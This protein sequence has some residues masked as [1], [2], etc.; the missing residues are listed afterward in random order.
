MGILTS[1]GNVLREIRVRWPRSVYECYDCG[2]KHGYWQTP[3]IYRKHDFFFTGETQW[4]VEE[5]V[6]STEREYEY[7]C[8][9]CGAI[10]LY[11]EASHFLL[12]SINFPMTM[13]L[14]EWI[15]DDLESLNNEVDF[16]SI[17]SQHTDTDQGG[18][19]A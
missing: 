3:R 19:S 1:L 4:F 16:P 7:R 17:F 11:D 15:Q 2:A 12:E 8:L 6:D 5:G 10:G 13:K 9:T 18:N 14:H